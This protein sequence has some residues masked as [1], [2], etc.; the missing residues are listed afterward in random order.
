[1]GSEDMRHPHQK[2]IV[3]DK[4][5]KRFQANQ[6]VV[7]LLDCVREGIKVDLNS[8]AKIPFF[9]EDYIQFYELIGYSVCGFG[10]LSFVSDK[11][12]EEATQGEG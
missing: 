9:S 10:D 6:V 7:Y 8:L 12:Y 3:D 4:G 1:M 2:I 5:V 11:V